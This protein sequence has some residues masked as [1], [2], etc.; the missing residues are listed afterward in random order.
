MAGKNWHSGT[1]SWSLVVKE[2]TK[3]KA[4]QAISMRKQG[5]TVEEIAKALKLSKSRIYEYLRK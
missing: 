5:K 4:A 2:E 3:K 1:K